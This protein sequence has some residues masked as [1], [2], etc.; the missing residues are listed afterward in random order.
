MTAAEY[1]D[2]LEDVLLPCAEEN[3]SL[4]WIYQQNNGLKHTSKL[5]IKYFEVNN[6]HVL[7]CP[8]QSPNL[9]PMENLC[10]ELK[11]NG[12]SI[13]LKLTKTSYGSTSKKLGMRYLN[14]SNRL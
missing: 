8:S 4:R 12:E 13:F 3:L 9:N 2:I 6:V 5:I 7:E 11:I 10:R 14:K 1:K